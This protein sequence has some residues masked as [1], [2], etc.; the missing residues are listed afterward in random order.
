MKNVPT[1]STGAHAHNHA[2]PGRASTFR[3]MAG[4]SARVTSGACAA[5]GARGDRLG[6]A[7][8]S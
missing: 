5:P 1:G 7:R 8:A 2:L 3:T 6:E 4:C